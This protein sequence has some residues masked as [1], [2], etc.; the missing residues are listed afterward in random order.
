MVD[1]LLLQ[2]VEKRLGIAEPILDQLG[3]LAIRLLTFG[4]RQ[5]LPEEAVVP[6]L[7]TVVEELIVAGYPG[8]PDQLDQRR[9][10]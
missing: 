7:R 5:A 10:A 1:R 4:G 6:Q 3:E 8:L 2:F 9:A